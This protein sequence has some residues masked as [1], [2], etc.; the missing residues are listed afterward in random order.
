MTI[1][2]EDEEFYR[3]REGKKVIVKWMPNGVGGRQWYVRSVETGAWW[4]VYGSGVC[5]LT[6]HSPEDIVAEW[7]D[8]ETAL[9]IE[10]GKSYV[11]GRGVVHRKAQKLGSG[12]WIFDDSGRESY[13]CENGL[14]FHPGRSSPEKDL[15]REAIEELDCGSDEPARLMYGD[16]PDFPDIGLSSLQTPEQ[17][18]AIKRECQHES[19][20]EPLRAVL[21]EAYEQAA[22]GKG[23]ER[24][25]NGKPFIQQPILEIAR[26]QDGTIAGHTF[27]VMKKAQEATRMAKNEDVE[28]AIHELYGVIVYAAA[29]V[30]LLQEGG[31]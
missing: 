18:E 26:M 27:Q 4:Y 25:A 5:L 17:K 12:N 23:N 6:D 21:D 13:F 24:H 19:N 8:E 29:A 10:E 2:L 14:F 11:D 1:Q 16:T 22:S 20:Y 3:T 15:V 28:K 9:K 7:A 31:E 30:I